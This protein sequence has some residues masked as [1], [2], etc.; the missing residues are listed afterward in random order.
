MLLTGVTMC[1]QFLSKEP[2]SSAYT[3]GMHYDNDSYGLLSVKS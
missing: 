3:H 2:S 1:Y